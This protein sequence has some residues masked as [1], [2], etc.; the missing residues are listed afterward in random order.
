MAGAIIGYNA[1]KKL[2]V[3]DDF[4]NILYA[5]PGNMSRADLEWRLDR[6]A[7]TQ[8]DIVAV[9][10]ACPDLCYYKTEVGETWGQNWQKD[11]P[12]PTSWNIAQNIQGLIAAADDPLD[13]TTER[14]HQHGLTV[15]A[16][17]RVN[18]RHHRTIEFMRTRFYL[19]HPEWVIEGSVNMDYT[20]P[21]VREH[22]LAIVKEVLARDV[23]GI[24]LDFIRSAPYV[25]P[26]A[27]ENA[28][29]LT[30][31]I[32]QVRTLLDDAAREK[33]RQMV[34]GAIMPW[35]LAL[36]E[37][38]GADVGY[39]IR[40]GWLDFVS[41][42]EGR[43]A[44]WNLPVDQWVSLVDG[45]D[46]LVCPAVIADMVIDRTVR[47][48]TGHAE[49]PM[50]MSMEHITACAQNFYSQGADGIAFYNMYGHSHG[51]KFSELAQLRDPI[52]LHSMPRHYFYGRNL[53]YSFDN[54]SDVARKL[55]LITREGE[56]AQSYS[57]ILGDR[58]SSEKAILRF[59]ALNM[60]ATDELSVSLNGTPLDASLRLV[61]TEETGIPKQDQF[62]YAYLVWE[63]PLGSPPAVVGR[64]MIAFKLRRKAVRIA[65]APPIV[66]TGMEHL[67]FP[68][69]SV[70][71]REIEIWVEPD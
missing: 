41:P 50:Q 18:D 11:Y 19:E 58:L 5:A 14:L 25:S 45:A 35:D 65:Q 42:S 48:D 46:C 71:I 52:A 26:P 1:P 37:S 64:N 56:E 68:P 54:L 61:P 40:E 57:F 20:V 69:D 24:S 63:I 2:I 55:E 12:S 15:L 60:V 33:G 49:G 27:A 13:V 39:W 36:L 16:G 21:Q 17:I 43:C 67:H 7:S 3:Q 62:S 44:D 31:F 66:P 47:A 34:L 8:A 9:D 30:E 22:R 28:Q 53:K 29:Y 23:D 70:A 51:R 4:S 10:M 38:L 6:L 32:R 59:K